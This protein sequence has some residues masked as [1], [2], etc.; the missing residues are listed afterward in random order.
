MLT[1]WNNSNFFHF[2]AAVQHVGIYGMLALWNN[3][4]FFHFFYNYLIFYEKASSQ[5]P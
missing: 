3:S 4:N 5:T 2:L 1:L